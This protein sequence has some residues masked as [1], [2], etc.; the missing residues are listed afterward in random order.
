MLT[1]ADKRCFHVCFGKLA[2]FIITMGVTSFSHKETLT[3][4]EFI[5]YVCYWGFLLLPSS[6][7]RVILFDHTV[8]QVLV[9]GLSGTLLALMWW[10]VVRYFQHSYQD[11]VNCKICCGLLIH[12]FPLQ[13]YDRD[14]VE[15]VA[16]RGNNEST[17][18]SESDTDSQA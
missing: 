14:D 1:V 6:W 17:D 8:S 3:H 4:L 9:G 13:D 7:A 10:R 15:D 12:N 16:K 18:A 11:R 2:F 5:S